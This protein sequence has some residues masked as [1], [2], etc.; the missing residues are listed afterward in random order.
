MSKKDLFGDDVEETKN[1]DSFEDLLR[2]S[3]KPAKKLSVGDK[4]NGEILSIGK[5]EVFISTSTPVD[6]A[7]PIRE[8]LNEKKEQPY[9]VGDLIEVQVIRLRENEILLK[10]AGSLGTND[11]VD[12]LEDAFDM[13][14]PVAGK[15]T[16]VTKGGYRISLSGKTAFCPLSQLDYRNQNEPESYIG[17]KFDFLITQFENQGRNIVVSRRKLLDLQ[18]AE[19]EGSFLQTHKVGDEL[20]GEIFRLEKYGAFMRSPQGIEALIPISELAWGRLKDSSEAVSIGQKVKA[21]ILKIEDGERMRISASLK[22]GEGEQN[23]PWFSIHEKFPVGSQHEGT[24]ERKEPYGLFVNIAPGLTGLMPRSK[25]RDSLD[26]QKLENAKKGE[27]L[28]IQI[29]EILYEDR[30][31]SFGLPTEETDD[32]WKKHQTQGSFSTLGD[33]F[34]NFKKS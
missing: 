2:E 13:E 18:K 24:I 9:K 27:K 3:Y 32:S 26:A 33:A 16:E 25:W 10:K 5:D 12:S 29:D 34:K 14:I 1:M 22:Q 15:V 6:G 11:D 20:E 21:K 30:K 8:L 19:N 4:F 17:K 7:L 31:M 23:N 28:R